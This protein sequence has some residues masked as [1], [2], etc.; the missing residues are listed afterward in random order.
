MEKNDTEITNLKHEIYAPSRTI[1]S[2][3]FY[4]KTD[5]ME[6]VQQTNLAVAV[7]SMSVHNNNNSCYVVFYSSEVENNNMHSSITLSQ[8]KF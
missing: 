8:L 7:L 2:S 6:D 4:S 5:I 1:L 3:I